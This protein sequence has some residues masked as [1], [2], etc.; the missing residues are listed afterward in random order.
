MTALGGSLYVIENQR[1]WRVS[2]TTGDYVQ[3]DSCAR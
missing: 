3:I 2:P 1:L